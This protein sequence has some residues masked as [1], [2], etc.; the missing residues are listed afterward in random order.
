[1]QAITNEI[2]N[3]YRKI[4]TSVKSTH[5]NIRLPWEV[6]ALSLLGV[7]GQALPMTLSTA[8]PVAQHR[9]HL[10]SHVFTLSSLEFGG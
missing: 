6:G 3:I 1:M 2:V 4:I 9:K 5:I 10:D 7:H 8:G